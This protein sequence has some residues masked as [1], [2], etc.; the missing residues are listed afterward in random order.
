MNKFNL[1][2]LQRAWWL[3]LLQKVHC[4]QPSQVRA[5]GTRARALLRAAA[6]VKIRCN[7][8]DAKLKLLATP[9]TF[10]GMHR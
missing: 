8:A 4:S 2:E 6:G 5:V 9:V 1:P 7:V 3:L 10:D